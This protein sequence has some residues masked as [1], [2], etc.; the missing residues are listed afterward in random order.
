MSTFNEQLRTDRAAACQLLASVTVEEWLNDGQAEVER[1]LALWMEQR[2]DLGNDDVL[3]E[4]AW[5]KGLECDTDDDFKN[6][7][8]VE[9]TIALDLVDS[10]YRVRMTPEEAHAFVSASAPMW[11][12]EPALVASFVAAANAVAPRCQYQDS[13]N[14][15][16]GKLP[17]FWWV[18]RETYRVLY[19][20]LAKLYITLGV[21]NGYDFPALIKQLTDLATQHGAQECDV[22]KD[23]TL[24]IFIRFY[25]H[26]APVAEQQ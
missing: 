17:H 10:H 11:N 3:I 9:L 22:V 26:D 2:L 13:K 16:N 21:Q 18:G 15:N 14:P 4:M 1:C 24:S 5:C 12:G 20:D 19:F 23:D 25:W 6:S 7:K 8:K